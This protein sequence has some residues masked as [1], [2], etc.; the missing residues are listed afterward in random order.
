MTWLICVVL[1]EGLCGRWQVVC[2]NTKCAINAQ[3]PTYLGLSE[4]SCLKKDDSRVI[5]GR[6]VEIKEKQR[7]MENKHLPPT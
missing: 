2:T 6:D 4:S 3:L 5:L 7:E 1:C